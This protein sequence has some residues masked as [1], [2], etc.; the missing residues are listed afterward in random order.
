[1]AL[2]MA[3]TEPTAEDSLA[4]IRARRRLGMAMDA[5]IRMMATTISN[6]INEKPFCLRIVTPGWPLV[7]ACS[8]PTPQ[9]SGQTES[10]S[11]EGAPGNRGHRRTA[12]KAFKLKR[13]IY[14]LPQ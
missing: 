11:E 3:R 7:M 4:E 1:M 14:A 10:S 2:L 12:R 13:A 6:S 9:F 5:M 8:A